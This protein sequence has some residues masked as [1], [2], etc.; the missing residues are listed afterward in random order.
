MNYIKQ[1]IMSKFKD[2]CRP[3]GY[4]REVITESLIIEIEDIFSGTQQSTTKEIVKKNIKKLIKKDYLS[5][6]SNFQGQYLFVTEK[7]KN[8][9][10]KG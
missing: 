6:S 10:S 8:K 9:Q 7:W 2:D 3:E 5:Y 4:S 1:K